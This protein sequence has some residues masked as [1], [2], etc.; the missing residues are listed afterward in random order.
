MVH[1]AHRACGAG[2]LE[3]AG[4]GARGPRYRWC[5]LGLICST[6]GTW[7]HTGTLGIVDDVVT[8]AGVMPFLGR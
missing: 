4:P 8:T 2:S 3:L 5:G 1:A 7:G 6:D